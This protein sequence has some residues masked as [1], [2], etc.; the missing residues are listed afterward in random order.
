MPRLYGEP[1]ADSQGGVSS[2]CVWSRI[3]TLACVGPVRTGRM[4]RVL[5][6]ENHNLRKYGY[7]YGVNGYR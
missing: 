2:G 1:E 7:A 6:E 5:S 4:A 3:V